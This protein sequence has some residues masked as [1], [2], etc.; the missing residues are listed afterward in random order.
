MAKSN[1]K[2]FLTRYDGGHTV[3]MRLSL[4]SALSDRPEASRLVEIFTK[5]RML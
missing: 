1:V 2:D 5:E 4:A 3:T